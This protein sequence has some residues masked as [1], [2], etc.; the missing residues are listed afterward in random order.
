VAADLKDFRGKITIETHCVVEA[1]H[2]VSGDDRREIVRKVLHEWAVQ[3][4]REAKITDALLRSEGIPGIVEGIAG[5]RGAA[6][7]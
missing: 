2:R 6:G 1:M 3:K 5:H 7:K 4:V